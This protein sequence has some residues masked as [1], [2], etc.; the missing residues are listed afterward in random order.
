MDRHATIAVI[1][2]TNSHHKRVVRFQGRTIIDP[3]PPRSDDGRQH[4][5]LNVGFAGEVGPEGMP[6]FLAH[7]ALEQR[8]EDRRLHLAPI[9]RRRRQQQ[10]DFIGRQLDRVDA[11]G[12]RRR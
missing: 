9:F 2:R 6:L 12:R 11:S 4:D 10:A 3:L 7:A 1:G 8:A 5:L